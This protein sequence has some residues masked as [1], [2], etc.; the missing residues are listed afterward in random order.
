MPIAAQPT[1]Q[2][3]QAL[4]DRQRAAR[5]LNMRVLYNPAD[6][7]CQFTHDGVPYT[8]P[9]DG[10]SKQR[11]GEREN[12]SR[13]GL[14]EDRGTHAVYDGT[15]TIWDRYGVDPKV[16]RAYAKQLKKGHKPPRKPFPD[17]LRAG[18][19]DIAEH[20]T[21]ARGRRGL[22]VLTGEPREDAELRTQAKA[23]FLTFK[24]SQVERILKN[25]QQRTAAFHANPQNRG[26]F[27][28]AMDEVE[29]AA[30]R[31]Y[32]EYRLG[33]QTTKQYVCPTN[34]GF[35]DDA[36]NVLDRHIQAAHPMVWAEMQEQLQAQSPSP[37]PEQ[38]TQKPTT[39]AA[40]PPGA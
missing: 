1:A 23:L 16:A 34:C 18:V 32:D 2:D 28:P 5:K 7:P 10:P 30:Q 36:A 20:A 9:P 21:K 27:A 40:P 3:F 11:F 15:L 8:V 22:V 25:Y 13:P 14:V 39:K 35:A 37:T 6:E 12:L 33:L 4:R 26:Q 31:W 38:K 29:R 24:V 19:L 17:Q